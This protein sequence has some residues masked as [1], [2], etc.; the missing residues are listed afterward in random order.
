VILISA[1]LERFAATEQ[2]VEAARARLGWTLPHTRS[3]PAPHYLV[4]GDLALDHVEML[5]GTLF[6]TGDLAIGTLDV[7]RC[8]RQLTNICVAGGCTLGVAYLDGF[9]AVRGALGCDTLVVDAAWDGGVFIGGDLV[10]DTLV[11]HNTGV[12]V[13]GVTSVEHEADLVEAPIAAR[14]AVPELF[15]GEA[16]DVRGYFLSLVSS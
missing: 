4:D 10:A 2:Q 13:D 7:Q 12:E 15:D 5:T 6:V 14:E 8:G 16:A 3:L 1:E 11:I 9:L